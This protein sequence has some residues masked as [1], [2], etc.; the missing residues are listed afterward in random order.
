MGLFASRHVGSSHTRALT[1]VPCISRQ[2]RNFWTT[3]EVTFPVLLRYDW[4]SQFHFLFSVHT[5]VCVL[6]RYNWHLT[7]CKFNMYSFL[8]GN[9]YI[10]VDPRKMW[11]WAVWSRLSVNFFFFTKYIL[12]YYMICGWL[13]LLMWSCRFEG[14]T[15]KFY[16]AFR[17][18]RVCACNPRLLQGSAVFQ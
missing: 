6:L 4:Q 15:V 16:A 7:L 8:V 12:S 5:R 17:L 1:C 3:G 10:H 14:P 11:V 9:I 2:I 13:K 18:H